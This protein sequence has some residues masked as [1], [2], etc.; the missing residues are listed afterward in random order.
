MKLREHSGLVGSWTD[1]L[2]G[3]GS[4]PVT[5]I[6]NKDVL[7]SF[8]LGLAVG[9]DKPLITLTSKYQGNEHV[10]DIF[11]RDDQFG[12]RLAEFL[13]SQVGKTIWDIG[14]AEVDF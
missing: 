8:S 14:D 4:A 2:G 7:V 11:V 13:Q 3:V 12:Q 1:G 5:P 6:D 10:R 9:S